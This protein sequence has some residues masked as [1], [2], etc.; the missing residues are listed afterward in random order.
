MGPQTTQSPSAAGGFDPQRHTAAPGVGDTS[1]SDALATLRKRLWLLIVAALLGIGYGSYK[2]LTQPKLY[3]ATSIIQVQ[4]GSS[5]QYRLDQN[6][7]YSDDSQTRMNT[8]RLILKSDTLLTEVAKAMDLANNPDFL[9]ETGPGPHRSM[10]DP[11]V[12]ADVVGEL[13]GNLTVAAIPHTEMMQ[14]SYSS[15]SPKLSADIVNQIVLAYVHRAYQSPVDR[16]TTVSEWLSTQLDKLKL[17][18]AREQ[19]QMMDLQRKMGAIGYDSSHNEVQTSLEGLLSAE[20]AAKVARINA[21]SRWNMVRAMGPNTLDEAIEMTPGT[22]PGELNSLR[23]QLATA[24]SNYAELMNPSEG[25][26]GPNNPRI[27]ALTDQMIQ[28][29]KAITE[30]QSRLETQSHQA[31]LAAKAAEDQIETELDTKKAEAYKQGD[32][33][34]QYT[35]VQR[36]YEQD[37]TL[38]E[39]LEQRLQTAK[40]EAG[41]G[42]TEVDTVDKALPPVSPT[43]RSPVTIIATTTALF[44]L[45]AIVLAFILESLDT[46]LHNIQE[47]EDVMEMPSLAIIPKA[48]RSTPEQTAAMSAT[49]RNINVLA[50][51]KS[52]FAEAF[53]SLRTSLLLSTSGKPP[54]FILFTSAA[55]SE[56]KTTMACNLACILSHGDASV[57]LIDADLRR[58]NVHHRFSLAGKAGLTT[59]LAGTTSF[60]QARQKVA[61]APHLDIL[62]SGPVPPFPTEMLSSDAMRSL[63]K[64][65][66]EEYTYVIIDSPPILSVT[67]AAI[68]GQVADAVVMVIRHGKSSKNILRRAR[69]LMVRS[70]AP[71]AGLVVN[72]VDLNSPEYHGYYGYS[73]YSYGSVD[74][75]SWETQPGAANTARSAGKD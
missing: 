59:V 41:L 40:V 33:L 17:Q 47:I 42:A 50:Q 5:A 26:L 6:Y 36:E 62:P 68:L 16:T 69:D 7:D 57:L 37:R 2:A 74:A 49:Q 70:G 27:K 18:V 39:G 55:P 72:A 1:L 52:Q 75:D 22:M 43:L 71:I 4:S 11:Q 64:H 45:G 3:D 25:G 24:Q 34:V 38:Y 48:K 19:Q 63:L 66:G 10:D 23:A 61:E 35:V 54:K 28:L 29:R 31:F 58:P 14:I 44:L 67:D 13:G 15:L 53:R 12:H 21:E 51:P 20:D 30:E 46:R 60:E 9:G 65:V 73:G 56:G 32:D 8:E